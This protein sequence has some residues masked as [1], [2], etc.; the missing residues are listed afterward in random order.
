MQS[1]FTQA[2]M[3]KTEFSLL[4]CGCQQE[5]RRVQPETSDRLSRQAPTSAPNELHM[6]H[7]G[8]HKRASSGI[9]NCRQLRGTASKGLCLTSEMVS[10]KILQT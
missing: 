7:Q 4:G 1:N 8:L 9:H 10:V 6:P 5:L 3:K 2:W